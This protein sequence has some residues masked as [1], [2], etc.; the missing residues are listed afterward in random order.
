VNS[1]VTVASSVYAPPIGWR[2]SSDCRIRPTAS[3][4]EPWL[5]LLG[6]VIA[7]AGLLSLFLAKTADI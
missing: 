6:W 3:Y 4:S 5:K 7:A 1:Q 2:Q